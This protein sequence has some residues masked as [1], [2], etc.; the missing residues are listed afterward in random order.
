MRYFIISVFLTLLVGCEAPG[1]TVDYDSGKDFSRY[2]TFAYISDHPLMRDGGTVGTSPLLEGRLIQTTENI[3]SA[4]GFKRVA[5][6]EKADMVIGFT[7]GSRE[8][9][10]VNSYPEVYRPYYNRGWGWGGT[11]YG[12]SSAVDVQQYTEGTLAVDIYDVKERKPVWHSVAVRRIT[13]KMREN[14]G[15]VIRET[16][17]SMFATFPP[18]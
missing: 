5:D 4:R 13:K 17:A 18:A 7:I 9:I 1:P 2:R 6:R 14:P 10:R 11:Y 15:D 8:K 12:Q 16:L 3:L